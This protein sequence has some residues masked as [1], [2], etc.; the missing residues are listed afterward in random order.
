M[1]RNDQV[2]RQWLLLQKLES[3]SGATLQELGSALPADYSRHPRTITRMPSNV[4]WLS[5]KAFP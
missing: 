4:T 5:K 3:A 1:S 2:T